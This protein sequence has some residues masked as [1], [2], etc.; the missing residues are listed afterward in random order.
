MDWFQAVI[1]ALVQG[2]CEFLPISSS[3]HLILPSALL[4]W[5]DQG[6]A[7][8]VAVHIGSLTAVV[9][10]FRSDLR[11]VAIGGLRSVLGKQSETGRLAWLLVLATIPALFIAVLFGSFIEENLRS[12]TVIAYATI[13]GGII[14][15]IAD[16][17]NSQRRNLAEMTIIFALLIG[18]AQAAALIPGMSRSGATITMALL[19]GFTPV[20]A[21][22][23]SFLLSVPI[24]LASGFWQGLSLVQ[25]SEVPWGIIG[26]ATLVS[27]VSAYLCIHYFL[28]F[29]ERIGMMPFVIYRLILG[30]ALLLM[31]T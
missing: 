12:A 5:P 21:A 1:L 25:A 13:I 3:G 22:R 7:F 11:A 15:G 29:I 31:F 27:G 18:L 23:F 17:W 8:D 9:V 28:K 16:K 10:Y 2:L 24:I 6:L 4:G 19:L 20:A 26:L 30:G 14:L